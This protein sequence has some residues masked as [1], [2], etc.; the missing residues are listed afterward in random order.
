MLSSEVLVALCAGAGALAAP[1]VA[2]ML[3]G[4]R[5]VESG[6]TRTEA[7]WTSEM[8]SIAPAPRLRSRSQANSTGA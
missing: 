4:T 6:E 8:S 7:L 2:G 3:F 1:G 5:G